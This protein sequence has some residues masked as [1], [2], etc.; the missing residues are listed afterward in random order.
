MDTWLRAGTAAAVAAL[1][2]TSA[3]PGNGPLPPQRVNGAQSLE[4]VGF[5]DYVEPIGRM[6]DGE[7][8]VALE[9]RPA[10]WRPWGEEGATIYT[11]VFAV[12]G[13]AARIPS[14]MIRV[15][16]GTPIRVTVRNTFDRPLALPGFRDRAAAPA[17]AGPP[18]AADIIPPGETVELRF[19]PTLPGT[20][21]YPGRIMGDVVAPDG[22]PGAGEANRGMLGVLIVDPP[23]AQP[24]PEERILLITH[25]ADTTLSGTYLP[26]TR[27]FINGR[28][29]PHTP[30]LTYTQGDTARWRVIN[31]TGRPHPMHLHGF[32]YHVDAYG[33][34]GREQ[35]YTADERPLVVTHV[36]RP[37][38]AM[39]MSWVAEEPGN[40]VFHCHFMRHMSSL[41]HDPLDGGPAAVGGGHE[42]DEWL[43]ADDLALLG[44]LVIGITVN[45]DPAIP[46]QAEP[47][48]RQV[49]L[50]IGKRDSVFGHAPAY[51][52]VIQE[53]A[54]EPAPDSVRLPASLLE[55]VR[56]E[57]T[58][59]VVHNRADV[60]LGVHW[61]GLE[62]E[63]RSDGVPG[64][65][66]GPAAAVPAIRPGDSL[67]VRITPRRAG[68]FMYHVHSE[69]GHQLAAGLYGALLVSE[70]DAAYAAERDHL[71]LLGSLGAGDDPPPAINGRSA[72]AAM[73]LRSGITHRL[74]FMHISPDDEKRVTL[75][76]ANGEPVTWQQLAKDGA[77]LP[78][79]RSR[80]QPAE[81]AIAVGETWDFVWTP[82]PGN[83]TL[84][85]VTLFDRGAPLF[86]RPAPPPDTTDVIVR[87]R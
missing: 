33:E 74:R 15:S 25:W 62:L 31:F 54:R 29:W 64:W 50:F 43:A 71:F 60:R 66:G 10:L 49:R 37:A 24:T 12:A 80:A 20:F 47:S 59:I 40:W 85:V 46:A 67:A 18:P 26:A 68:T 76:D 23:D 8:H 22:L 38:E 86:P 77:D 32:Y 42:R 56:G 52:F 14:P 79:T 1:V 41:Q 19:T 28:S 84:R 36:L 63:S 45:R 44:G 53:G 65:S 48:R 72:P 16:A 13:Q 82:S 11:H 75:T 3:T 73:E 78:L 51:G 4:I 35:V 2:T 70:P 34:I 87:V 57:P 7:L 61:H 9:A 69:P 27:M 5:E 21:V 55:L 17:A 6:V 81:L 58:E 83:Y 39:R 30:R